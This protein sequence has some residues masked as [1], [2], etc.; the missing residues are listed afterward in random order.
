[1]KL[2]KVAFYVAMLILFSTAN[3]ESN[4]ETHIAIV[5]D[6]ESCSITES[7]TLRIALKQYKSTDD[8]FANIKLEEEFGA[9]CKISGIV[10]YGFISEDVLPTLKFAMKLAQ[11][12]VR[13]TEIIPKIHLWL[14]S[15]GGLISEAMKIGDFISTI[16]DLGV[17]VM[18]NGKCF[19]ACVLILAAAPI[20]SGIGDVGIHRP[21][22]YEITTEEMN[23]NQYLKKYEKVMEIMRD[24]Y[25]KYGVSM[26]LMNVMSTVPSD[27]IR[28]IDWKIQNEWGFNA[29]NLSNN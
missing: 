29:I 16:N 11:K 10:L 14:N 18:N 8:I 23:Y 22:S 7:K 25:Q 1:M 12:R 26:A 24:Y 3:A 5:L 13:N 9:N 4:N 20:R 2:I 6:E 27:E 15:E 28:I 19:S 17:I 21:F